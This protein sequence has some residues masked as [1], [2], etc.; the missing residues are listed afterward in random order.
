MEKENI[1]KLQ[2]E[3]KLDTARNIINKT[4]PILRSK[5]NI[6]TSGDFDISFNNEGRNYRLAGVQIKQSIGLSFHQVT[7][8]KQIHEGFYVTIDKTVGKTKSKYNPP[9]VNIL[10]IDTKQK[11]FSNTKETVNKI[12]KFLENFASKTN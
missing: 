12:N 1:G 3:E 5:G 2:E 9:Y 7:P 8:D 10:F 4:I 11:S 6:D